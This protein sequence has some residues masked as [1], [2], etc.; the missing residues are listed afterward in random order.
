MSKNNPLNPIIEKKVNPLN[1]V[2]E[3]TT[4]TT[5]KQ[6]AISQKGIDPALYEQLRLRGNTA[7]TINKNLQ[8]EKT[9][10]VLKTMGSSLVTAAGDLTNQ[11][12]KNV[13][14]TSQALAT[15]PFVPGAILGNQTSKDAMKESLSMAK[16]VMMDKNVPFDS[17]VQQA[18]TQFLKKYAEPDT[19]FGGYKPTLTNVSALA[20]LGFFNLFGDPAFEYGLGLKGVKAL[21]E[22]ATFKKVGEATKG[23]PEGSSFLKGT[24][25]ELE[26]KVSPDI[27]IKI[28]PKTNE[29]VIKG[30]QRRFPTQAGLPE[31]QL[32][33]ETD[34]IIRNAK[35]MTGMDIIARVDGEDLVLKP[36]TSGAQPAVSAIQ[37]AVSAIQSVV[38]PNIISVG[39]RPKTERYLENPNL[40]E[41][42]R[43]EYQSDKSLGDEIVL[44]VDRPLEQV[45]LDAYIYKV[46][47]ALPKRIVGFRET[48]AGMSTF[49]TQR[50]QNDGTAKIYFDLNQANKIAKAAGAEVDYTNELIKALGGE[51]KELKL[52][53]SKGIIDTT[54]SI[55]ELNTQ[56]EATKPGYQKV[57]NFFDT[58][59]KNKTML[60]EDSVIMKTLLEGTNDKFLRDNIYAENARF[61]SKFGFHDIIAYSGNRPVASRIQIKKGLTTSDPEIGGGGRVFA[62]EFFHSGYWV[63]LN[64]AERAIVN[65]VYTSLRKTD[66]Q[67]I[68]AGTSHNV[69]HHIKNVREFFA[70]SGSDYVYEHKVPAPQMEPLLDKTAEIFFDRIKNLILR[71]EQAAFERLRPL[72]EKILAGDRSTPLS[73]FADEEPPSFK[74]ELQQMVKRKIGETAPKT[75]AMQEAPASKSLFSKPG[76]K[77]VPVASLM[78]PVEK[79]PIENKSLQQTILDAK[80]AYDDQQRSNLIPPPLDE[81]PEETMSIR[82]NMANSP[83][84]DNIKE[85]KDIANVKVQFRDVYRNTKEVFGK[86]S[87][88]A[89]K[90]LLEPLN[91]AKSNYI[92]FLNKETNDLAANVKFGVESKESKYVQ[93]YG[94]G[95]ATK[96]ELIDKFGV[97]TADEIIKADTFFRGKYDE[98]IAKI[99][100]IEQRIYP[101]SPY[102]WTP[103]KANY[104]R[105]FFEATNE[106][107]RLQN[108]LEN[109]IKI[110]PLLVGITETTAP[111][112]KWASFKQRRNTEATKVDAVGGYINY[113][114]SAAYAINI[115]PQIGRIREFSEV[116]KRG[117]GIKKNLNNYIQNLT[118]IANELSGKTH[119]MDRAVMEVIPGGRRGL[120]SLSWLNRRVKANTILLSFRSSLAQILNLPQGLATAGPIN[121]TKGAIK[122]AAQVFVEGPMSKSIFIKERFFKGFNQFD[123]GVLKSAK[124]FAVWMVGALDEAGTKIIWNGQYEKAIGMSHPNPVKFADDATRDL[125]GGRGIAEKPTI[126][127]SNTFQLLAPFQYEMT[128]VWWVMEDMAKAD[129]KIRSRIGQFMM[130]F[131]YLYLMDNMFEKATGGRPLFD[132]IEATIDGI[133]EIKADTG[134]PGWLKAGGRLA[135]EVVSNLPMGQTLGQVYPEYGANIGGVKLPSRKEFFGSA[136][137][138]R[139]G[140]GLLSTKALSDPLFKILPSYG[141]SQIK[142][143]LQGLSAV[144]QGEVRSKPSDANP[145]GKFLYKTDQNFRNY[146]QGIFFGKYALPESVDYYKKQ[147]A[148]KG[149]DTSGGNPLDP[150]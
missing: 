24:T 145:E 127:N 22:F 115:D 76:T 56:Y 107:S 98:L 33:Q 25:R 73:K 48:P 93:L 26:L 63:I 20:A 94:E 50:V 31:G 53:S 84:L 110:D 111:K 85:Y 6:E 113:L 28:Q 44:H 136:D 108:I 74:Q 3:T 27:K 12:F 134:L 68:F 55:G 4:A 64:D 38:K 90:I 46:K 57:S 148:P 139:F 109:P 62:H 150:Q 66:K 120:A 116:L 45:E 40:N 88:I 114:K 70:Q 83:I 67:A 92:D 137:P 69:A 138:T 23:L 30:Y 119:I 135:G 97:A 1:P 61:K 105:H 128:N 18:A 112:S 100:E 121:S 39:E 131:V 81:F 103:K 17:G 43:L 104:Y 54:K 75:T 9:P 79:P 35:E 99:N 37:P 16:T 144:S 42:S 13:R 125:V 15:A 89:D 126:Q 143:S 52:K 106:F 59:V 82:E 49:V 36:T 65:E 71:D 101:N 91:Q 146:L 142:K 117:T 58:M 60:P 10:G 41:K 133:Q 72:F 21:K 7:D 77:E 129:T 47:Q 8:P 78:P 80:K 11:M 130:F 141:G 32:S 102:K 87:A 51:G 132:P 140:E 122:A 123:K 86:D 96:A 149:I 19:K 124:K 147:G 29:V 5:V 118:N 14:G 2:Y 34:E 95:K